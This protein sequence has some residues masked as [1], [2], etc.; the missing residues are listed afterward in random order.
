[1]YY[2]EI[3]VYITTNNLGI[4]SRI[5]MYKCNNIQANIDQL[6]QKVKFHSLWWLK[7]NKSTLMFDTHRWWSDPLLCLGID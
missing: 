3:H 7:A 1:M 6:V 4:A 5:D 2:V